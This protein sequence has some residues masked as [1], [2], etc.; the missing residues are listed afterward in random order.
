LCECVCGVCVCVVCEGVGGVGVCGGWVGGGVG[1][2]GVGGGG[3]V[4]EGGA[5]Y[6]IAQLLLNR[7]LTKILFKLNFL[8]TSNTPRTATL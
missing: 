4:C 6:F 3:C 7:F 8:G 1:V 5:V 2:C